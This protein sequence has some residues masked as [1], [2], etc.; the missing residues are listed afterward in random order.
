MKTLRKIPLPYLISFGISLFCFLLA[1]GTCFY[2]DLKSLTIWTTNIWD[3]LYFTG[4]LREYYSFTSQNLYFLD[5]SMVGSDILIYIPWAIWNLPIWFIQRFSGIAITQS[6]LMLL[7]SKCFLLLILVLALVIIYRIL[8][9]ITLSE[10]T[11]LS[12]ITILCSSFFVLTG[13]AYIGQNDILV[14]IV[15][16]LALEQL[17]N[18]HK[19]RFLLLAALSIA[20]KPFFIF[21][22][23]AI[24][25]YIEKKLHKICL[26]ALCG[27]SIYLIQKLPFYKAPM[28]AE[29]LS[30]GPTGN[31]IGLLLEHTIPL[32]RVGISVFV[33]SLL[34]VYFIAY[35]DTDT[36][37]CAHRYIYYCTLPFISL[38]AFTN[39]ECYRPIYL[40]TL[41]VI[42][43]AFKPEYHR[44]NLILELLFSGGLIIF[45]MS[46]DML[47]YNP[48]YIHLPARHAEFDSIYSFL[49]NHFPN[50]GL[51]AFM[52]L[53]LFALIGLA[54]INHPDFKSE[55]KI[56]CMKEE[57]YL[58]ILRSIIYSFPFLFA[59][60]LKCII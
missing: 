16:L 34:A 49:Q 25:L 30:Y 48:D 23:I 13:I 58:P 39:Y 14:I 32:S 42:L 1:F 37:D 56:L 57:K 50:V 20:L 35:L 55:N 45:Y 6:P 10:E 11:A 53:S 22:Y 47:F 46:T 17:L 59:I 43:N 19:K 9:K 21:S 29:S 18:S 4:N 2:T 3:T 5:H 52:A 60:L 33:L 31:I 40:I 12:N 27:M 51:K 24:I 36:K 8:K 7:Y 41:L 26:Y 15:F 28:Y 38:F 54:I 44:I